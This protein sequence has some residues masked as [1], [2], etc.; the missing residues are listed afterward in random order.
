M[1]QNE[2][3]FLESKK[4]DISDELTLLLDEYYYLKEKMSKNLWNDRYHRKLTKLTRD[5]D[6]LKVKLDIYN[7][8]LNVFHLDK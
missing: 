5:V 4:K 2:K 1:N 7:D 8:I 6:L 3:M